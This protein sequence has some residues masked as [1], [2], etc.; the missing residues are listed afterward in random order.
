[1]SSV[2]SQALAGYD[3]IR[4]TRFHDL[5][6]VEV[7]HE[8]G[9]RVSG[10]KSPLVLLDLDSTLY[11]VAPRTFA[12]L[13]EW[14]A[15]AESK[16]FADVRAHLAKLQEKHVGYSV[17]DTF[18]AV[19]IDMSTSEAE[20]ALESAKR[21]WSRRFFTSAYLPHDRAY[22][23]AAEFTRRLHVD[24]AVIVYL[25]GRDAPNMGEGTRA[26]LIRD[27]FPWD[28]DRTHLLLKES[29]SVL[30]LT[31]KQQAADYIR[32][33]GTL[34]ASFE[35]E[36]RNLVALSDIFPHAMHVFVQTVFSDHDAL[37]GDG[38]YR[39]RGFSGVGG[40]T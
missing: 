7:L 20:A 26:N 32:R 38:I 18:T 37:P 4:A 5:S 1:M 35:N 21:F 28:V 16:P 36:P 9:R 22:P 34:I 17:R 8:V 19:G 2:Q 10:V 27:G 24:G 14:L 30:D 15:A 11:E 23:G 25:T 12:I 40:T 3:W 6:E 29:P 33:H 31:H 13:G 39:I